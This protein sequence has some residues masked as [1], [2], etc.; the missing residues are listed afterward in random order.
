MKI[1]INNLN[2]LILGKIMNSL[3][4]YLI[5]KSEFIQIYSIDGI[6]QITDS[7]INKINYIDKDVEVINKYYNNF[8]LIK[9]TTTFTKETINYINESHISIKIK[10]Y[11]YKMNPSSKIKLIIEGNMNSPN[12]NNTTLQYD[13]VIPDNLYLEFPE[14]TDINNHYIKEEII[15]YLS[16]LNNII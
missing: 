3:N 4:K 15:E 1:Y 12:A 2:I 8:S 14:N 16:L 5:N 10:Q 11:C 6:Y 7:N 9:D 13:N